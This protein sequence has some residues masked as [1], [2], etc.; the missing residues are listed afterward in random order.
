M[1][2]YLGLP[3]ESPGPV[4]VTHSTQYPRLW[5]ALPWCPSVKREVNITNTEEEESL[6]VEML[7]DYR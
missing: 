1:V 4:S 6:S 3:S 5:F 7:D 2:G